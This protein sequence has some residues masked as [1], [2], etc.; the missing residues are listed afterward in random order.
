M[1]P[2]DLLKLILSPLMN[3]RGEV[4]VGDEEED[5]AKDKKNPPA[6]ADQQ[7]EELN[8]RIKELEEKT[9]AT[10]AEKKGIYADLKRERETRRNLEQSL[11]ERE[12]KIKE[13]TDED[14]FGNIG[15]DDLITGKHIKHLLRG[16]GER[17]KKRLALDLK[18]RADDRVALDEQRVEELCETK[19]EKYPIPY[20]DAIKAFLE[21]AE[22]DPSLWQA[23]DAA[24]HRSGGKP[25][26][27]AYKTALRE[28]PKFKEQTEIKAREKLLDEL[29]RAEKTPK[30]LRAG[31]GGG[32]KRLEDM[33]ED[34]LSNLSD[35][36]LDRLA[37]QK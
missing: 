33:S 20:E 19:P 22:K 35:E 5:E 27:Y 2:K 29:E 6:G 16:L 10:E 8:K 3:E 30:K 18:M 17:E 11:E 25:A 13:G 12:R 28:H 34:E 23:Y 21:L 32:S 31:S 36:E 37:R 24:K 4:R 1:N 9:A 26:D 14:A 7:L 15:D